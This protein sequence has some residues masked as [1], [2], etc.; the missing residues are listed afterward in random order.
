MNQ[1]QKEYWLKTMREH[2]EADRL[3]QGSW[4]TDKDD[5]GV[6]RGCFFGCAMQTMDEPI[7]KAADAMGVPYDVLAL[8]EKIFEGLPESEAT[9]WP[10]QFKDSSMIL[11]SYTPLM[12]Y[13][14]Y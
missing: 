7:E 8:A 1:Q 3:I 13:T 2:A 6:F 4:I 9:Q 14:H 5:T 11:V 10:V 12:A